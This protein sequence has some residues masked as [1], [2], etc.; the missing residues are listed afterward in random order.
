MGRDAFRD[1]S[2]PVRRSSR[3]SGSDEPPAVE[4]AMELSGPVASPSSLGSGA[5]PRSLARHPMLATGS[6]GRDCSTSAGSIMGAPTPGEAGAP[7]SPRSAGEASL[8][9]SLHRFWPGLSRGRTARLSNHSER[10][11]GPWAG[12]C[13]TFFASFFGPSRGGVDPGGCIGRV[14]PCLDTGEHLSR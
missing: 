8:S 11:D 10:E 12:L 4:T 7:Q 2:L 9:L 5:L 14:F 6:V 13:R 3:T 1:A